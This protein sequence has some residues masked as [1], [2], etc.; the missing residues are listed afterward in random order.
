MQCEHWAAKSRC[1]YVLLEAIELQDNQPGDCFCFQQ[2]IWPTQSSN[3][4][5]TLPKRSPS[6]QQR[7]YKSTSPKSKCRLRT[8]LWKN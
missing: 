7:T 1:P 3:S 5:A 4:G 8:S 2:T 6:S